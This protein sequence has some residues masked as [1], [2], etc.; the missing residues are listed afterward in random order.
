M[1][2]GNVLAFAEFWAF[3]AWYMENYGWGEGAL[4]ENTPEL[5]NS[6]AY[7]E[8]IK[9]GA[10]G[11]KTPEEEMA[12]WEQAGGVWGGREPTA[13]PWVSPWTMPAT[14][15]IEEGE[16][17]DIPQIYVDPETTRAISPTNGNGASP[18]WNGRKRA[19]SRTYSQP[20]RL[21]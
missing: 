16:A 20:Q 19:I 18:T 3:R 6:Q 8:W 5:R 9:Q 13:Q 7:Q 1:P 4:I 2:D 12:T 21:D 14:Q 15:P 10:P 11:W 17:Q